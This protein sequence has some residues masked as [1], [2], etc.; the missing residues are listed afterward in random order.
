MATSTGDY[1]AATNTGY[2]SAASA[3]GKSSF[4]IATGINSKAKGKIGCYIA[5]AEWRENSDGNY[6][7]I[8]FASHKV[9]GKTIKEDVYYTLK[10]GKFVE[11]D[12]MK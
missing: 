8:N 9:D 10:D 12:E 2:C 5:V 4:A 7:L 3:E 11:V 1:S 6:E